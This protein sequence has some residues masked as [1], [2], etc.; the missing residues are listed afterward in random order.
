MFRDT[1]KMQVCAQMA[2]LT[3]KEMHVHSRFIYGVNLQLVKNNSWNN[4]KLLLHVRA[5]TSIENTQLVER[6]K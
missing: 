6:L 3:L 2:L 1:D 4:K 5:Y